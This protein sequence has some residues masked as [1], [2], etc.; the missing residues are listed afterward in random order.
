MSLPNHPRPRP[1][2][3]RWVSCA[4][5]GAP[6]VVWRFMLVSD[7][8]RCQTCRDARERVRLRVPRGALSLCDPADVAG[9]LSF[10]EVK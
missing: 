8:T 10:V 2:D 5:C 7:P 6:I 1:N 4:D 9:A 3:A